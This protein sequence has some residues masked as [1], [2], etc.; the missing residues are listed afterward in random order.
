MLVGLILLNEYFS[1]LVVS[2]SQRQETPWDNLVCNI[3][4]RVGESA[5]YVGLGLNTLS[6]TGLVTIAPATVLLAPYVSLLTI[7][8]GADQRSAGILQKRDRYIL[9]ALLSVLIP[10]IRLGAFST[11]LSYT[12]IGGGLITIG[13]RVWGAYRTSKTG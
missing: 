8:V 10:W 1:Q 11:T 2:L 12:I 4:D 5:I 6:S 9:L 3:L 13:Q 7:V